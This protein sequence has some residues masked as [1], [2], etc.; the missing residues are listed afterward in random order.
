MGEL[1]FCVSLC[2]YYVI[3]LPSEHRRLELPQTVRNRICGRRLGL[4]LPGFIASV[5]WISPKNG[6]RIRS[7][8]Y[9]VMKE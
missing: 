8:D 7:I 9:P 5:M 4:T 1:F 2:S 3:I 6:T